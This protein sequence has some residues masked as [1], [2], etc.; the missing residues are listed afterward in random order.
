MRPGAD[1]EADLARLLDELRLCLPAGAPVGAKLIPRPNYR[2]EFT[3]E[4]GEQAEQLRKRRRE[5]LVGGASQ[6]DIQ[7]IEAKLLDLKRQLREGPQLKAGDCLSNRYFL[8]EEL[9]SGGFGTV[10]RALDEDTNHQVALKVLHGQHGDSGERYE[11]FWRGAKA[12]HGLAHPNIVR[13]LEQCRVDGG[14][15]YFAM[16]YLAGWNAQSGSDQRHPD[17]EE[18]SRGCC[19]RWAVLSTFAHDRG[20]IHRDVTPP[21]H[22]ARRRGYGTGPN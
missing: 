6:Q 15:Q 20:I 22:P 12:M 1:S 21:Q 3:R 9:D 7:V 14:Y 18:T 2:D 16:E 13:I 10:W 5:L 17:G 19:C 8:I 4:L 11:R